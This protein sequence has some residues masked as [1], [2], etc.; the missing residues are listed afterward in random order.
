VDLN[1]N[2]LDAPQPAEGVHNMPRRSESA[3]PS[4]RC[5]GLVQRRER[6]GLSLRGW[7]AG[8]GMAGLLIV[9]FVFQAYSF[10]AVT[11]RQPGSDFLV[12]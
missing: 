3:L 9:L 4:R 5:F 2:N 1:S 7:L 10:L 8:V 6:W 11:D 12:A